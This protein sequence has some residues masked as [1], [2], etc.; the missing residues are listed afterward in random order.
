[1]ITGAPHVPAGYFLPPQ[2]P[3]GDALA[4]ALLS[5][6]LGAVAVLHLTSRYRPPRTG[7]RVISAL[8]AGAAGALVAGFHAWGAQ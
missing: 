2:A 4:L 3:G 5:A 6:M 8:F 7:W 1:M